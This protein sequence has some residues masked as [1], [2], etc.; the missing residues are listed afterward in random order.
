MRIINFLD[1]YTI[2]L[3]LPEGW[4][5]CFLSGPL[6]RIHSCLCPTCRLHCRQTSRFRLDPTMLPQTQASAISSKDWLP[7]EVFKQDTDSVKLFKIQHKINLSD[8]KS[9]CWVR[10]EFCVVTQYYKKYHLRSGCLELCWT[11][12]P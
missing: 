2:L 8:A 12:Q 11:S 9:Q 1:Y 5:S 4:V 6:A 7:S 10:R 3:R